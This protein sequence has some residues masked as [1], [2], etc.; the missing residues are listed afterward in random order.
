MKWFFL[1]ISLCLVSCAQ[2]VPKPYGYFR[3]EMPSHDYQLSVGHEAFSYLHSAGSVVQ[4]LPEP[5]GGDWFNLVYPSLD[6]V[7]YCSYLSISKA[8]FGEVSEDSYQFVYKHAVRAS[9][10][11]PERFENTEASVYG[12]LYDVG[13]NVASPL[14]FVLTDSIRHFFR[15]ALYFNAVPNQDSVAPVLEYIRQ[16]VLVLMES[17]RWNKETVKNE[18]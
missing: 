14:Q 11:K 1:I 9:T 15:G 18:K 7:I 4:Y 16:D 10:I 6:A 5:E 13:G 17:F 2:Q 12:I 8:Q 3:I